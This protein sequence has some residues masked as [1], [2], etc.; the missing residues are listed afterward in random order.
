M[1]GTGSKEMGG[2]QF[3]F[4]VEVENASNFKLPNNSI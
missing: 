1:T 2:D 3:I 4:L